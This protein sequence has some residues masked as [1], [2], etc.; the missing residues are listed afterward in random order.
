MVHGLERTDQ[1]GIARHQGVGHEEAVAGDG[2][3]LEWLGAVR[4]HRRGPVHYSDWGKLVPS[5]DGIVPPPNPFPPDRTGRLTGQLR[6]GLI[7]HQSRVHRIELIERV[8]TSIDDS[9]VPG[10]APVGNLERERRFLGAPLR[11]HHIR[12]TYFLEA[13]PNERHGR[14]SWD[15]AEEDHVRARRRAPTPAPRQ[16]PHRQS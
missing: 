4:C 12:R 5:A 3:C 9:Q 6:K 13:L 1:F 14:F 8:V 15:P 7:V 2:L 16:S 11:Q 10:E